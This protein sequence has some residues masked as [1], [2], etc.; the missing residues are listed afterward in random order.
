MSINDYSFKYIY[1]VCYLKLRFY[2]TRFYSLV[3]SPILEILIL[4]FQNNKNIKIIGF[5]FW[6]R[7][8]FVR[9]R[10]VE[11]RHTFQPL[12]SSKWEVCN[13]P[14][15]PWRWHPG[16]QNSEISD[17]KSEKCILEDL[18]L[19]QIIARKL[20]FALNFCTNCINEAIKKEV[21]RF[22]KIT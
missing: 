14:S 7:L 17:W 10:F 11:H 18:L 2:C 21:S 12:S 3:Q 4:V 16:C 8:T 5:A 6:V 15:I 1:V 22:F 19:S 9:Y 20:N 13:K